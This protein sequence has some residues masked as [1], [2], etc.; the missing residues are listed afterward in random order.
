MSNRSL[1]L[2][3]GELN[4]DLFLARSAHFSA[5]G[6]LRRCQFVARPGTLDARRIL[7]E[8]RV[9]IF[10]TPA[11]STQ[12]MACQASSNPPGRVALRM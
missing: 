4:S 8:K 7:G 3:R 1:R 9:R 5:T 12:G 11:A 10:S 6:I 2:S